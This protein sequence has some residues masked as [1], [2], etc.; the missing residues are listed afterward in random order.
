MSSRRISQP[1]TAVK[2]ISFRVLNEEFLDPR[3]IFFSVVKY[4]GVGGRTV[5]S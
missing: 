2:E 3:L 5:G 1:T 4:Y